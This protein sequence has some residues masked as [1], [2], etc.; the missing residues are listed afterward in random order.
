MLTNV[1]ADHLDLQGLHTLPELV[2]VKSVICRVTT[3]TGTVVLNADDSLVASV[4]VRVKAAVVFFSEAG[5]GALLRRHIRARRPRVLINDD[6]TLVEIAAGKR[7]RIVA[8]AEIPATLG[9][10]ARHNVANALA[11]AAGARA[12]GF[13][14]LRL[15]RDC[16]TSTSRPTLCPAA[17]TSTA[18]AIG[19]W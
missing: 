17:S 16:A 5:P 18:A 7:R 13:R 2:E 6:G 10:L 19:W 9:G 12:L 4:G 1:S 8:A 14:S 15:P 3:P 11:A